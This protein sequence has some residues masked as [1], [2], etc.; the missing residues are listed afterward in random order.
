MILL[1][2]WKPIINILYT[3]L[4]VQIF[5]CRKTYLGGIYINMKWSM[6][7]VANIVA[8]QVLLASGN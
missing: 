1:L 7:A 3:V 6:I 5:Q 2:H 4:H 8:V